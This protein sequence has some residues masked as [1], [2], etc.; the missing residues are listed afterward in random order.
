MS[1]VIATSIR[2]IR[3]I[4]APPEQFGEILQIIGDDQAN[5][6]LLVDLIEYSPT[7][8]A[9]LLQVANSA[10]FG[11]RRPIDNVREAVIRVLGLSLTRSLTL[12]FFLTDRLNTKTVPNFDPH[13][14]WFSAIVTAKLA[15]E[16]GPN[17]RQKVVLSP[18]YTTG[19]LHNIGLLALVQSFP[20]QMNKLLK[21]D[22]IPLAKKTQ[23]LFRIDHYQAGALLVKSW[24]LP[25]NI[26]EPIAL[27][28][29][30]HYT[31]KNSQV[32]HLIRLSAELA[33]IFYEKDTFALRNYRA[34]SELIHQPFVDK[35]I[36]AIEE[37]LP[38]IEEF[39]QIV[40][41]QQ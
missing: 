14:H 20:K 4:P 31:G 2:D 23:D 8:A 16:M 40:I 35:A 17:L 37:Q 18:L 24:Q 41:Q 28:R 38:I 19:L 1:S 32:A 3:K 27:L 15:Q 6:M 34:P 29:N 36:F 9:R 10:F 21:E 30:I 11:Q 25:K 39:S 5:L 22:N 7:I 26:S 12:A 13:R 33:T